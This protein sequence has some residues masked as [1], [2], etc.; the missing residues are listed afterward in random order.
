MGIQL[1]L[2]DR[3][4]YLGLQAKFLLHVNVSMHPSFNFFIEFNVC[5]IYY[6]LQ[7]I[8]SWILSPL[9]KLCWTVSLDKLGMTKYS[10][11]SFY[12]K[13][14][15]NFIM[16][17]KSFLILTHTPSIVRDSFLLCNYH[18]QCLSNLLH[19][20]VFWPLPC[21]NLVST[22]LWASFVLVD[23]QDN[24]ILR[25]RQKS[26]GNRDFENM[27]I[28]TYTSSNRKYLCRRLFHLDKTAEGRRTLYNV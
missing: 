22:F 19:Q 25:Q 18:F 10:F 23:T 2:F 20:A 11:K 13:L 12:L 28:H 1:K 6:L 8:F 14:V 24:H 26:Q 7:I 3:K 9:Q 15:Q 16:R 21:C 5:L 17:M 27:C 4:H